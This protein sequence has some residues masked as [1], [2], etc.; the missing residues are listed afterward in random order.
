MN[1]PRK[2][3]LSDYTPEDRFRDWR[4]TLSPGLMAMDL[5]LVEYRRDLEG[6]LIPVALVELT[7]AYTKPISQLCKAGVIKRIFDESP[8]GKILTTIA[9]M[10]HVP[11]LILLFAEDLSEVWYYDIFRR[12]GWHETSFDL[13]AKWY[14]DLRPG[15]RA[16]P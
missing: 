10:L 1:K 2:K 15:R 6:N 9:R 13:L 11:A 14:E 16:R 12:D 5:D 7:S 4:R 3:P 8:Q